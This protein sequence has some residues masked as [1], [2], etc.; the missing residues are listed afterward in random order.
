MFAYRRKCGD[1]SRAFTSN[2]FERS[3][4]GLRIGADEA[5]LSV[6][7]PTGSGPGNG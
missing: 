3:L 4:G 2:P 7:T 6:H 1:K 5:A